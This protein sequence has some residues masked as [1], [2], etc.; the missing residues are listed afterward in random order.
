MKRVVFSFSFV[1]QI[2]NLEGLVNTIP[3][4]HLCMSTVMLILK[5]TNTY[6]LLYLF[7]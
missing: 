6:R 7:K 4:N 1:S 2:P 3:F 5:L